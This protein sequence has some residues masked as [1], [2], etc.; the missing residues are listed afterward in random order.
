MFKGLATHRAYSLRLQMFTAT[1]GL[2]PKE[3]MMK[4]AQHTIMIDVVEATADAMDSE[5]ALSQC[6]R[7]QLYTRWGEVNELYLPARY[8]RKGLERALDHEHP[9]MRTVLEKSMGDAIDAMIYASVNDCEK[10]ASAAGRRACVLGKKLQAEFVNMDE[11]L[12][13]LVAEHE[14][15]CSDRASKAAKLFKKYDENGD[16]VFDR[17]EF[18]A[19]LAKIT[20]G[21]SADDIEELWRTAGGKG[22]DSTLDMKT[23]EEKL[24]SI[25]RLHKA[26]TT[27][28]PAKGKKAL[29]INAHAQIA[30]EELSVLVALWD[31][32]REAG[33]D[34]SPEAKEHAKAQ[35]EAV[36]TLMQCKWSTIM[37][38]KVWVR[39]RLEKWRK[40][41]RETAERQAAS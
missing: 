19:M 20:P 25:G 35:A 26:A 39:T 31:S 23:L 29:V 6:R 17:E 16:G 21:A 18:T 10:A 33:E 9:E 13:V 32:V 1:T 28:A 14:A 5:R 37:R 22:E 36:E 4:P 30:R 40:A 15:F 11:V 12:Q 34:E 38:M 2:F 41:A 7:D 24:F 27:I 3:A 8:M